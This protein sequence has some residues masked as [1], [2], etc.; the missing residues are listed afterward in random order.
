MTTRQAKHDYTKHHADRISAHY[1]HAREKHPYF[2]D[3]VKPDFATASE[4]TRIADVLAVVRNRITYGIEH[5]SL[6]WED[7][8]D[9]ELW[10]VF[11][12]LAK[13]DTAHA[14]EEVYDMIAVCLRAIDVLE[15][16]QKLGKPGMSDVN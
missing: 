7:L 3:W 5:R 12:A 13:G 15:G 11:N 1:R 16:R 4:K 10:E 9:C 6:G 14:I 8:L 2:C